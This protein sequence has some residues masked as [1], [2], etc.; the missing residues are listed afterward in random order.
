[1][2]FGI[3]LEIGPT[4]NVTKVT[5]VETFYITI[6]RSRD[7]KVCLIITKVDNEVD[8]IFDDK[9]EEV[10]KYDDEWFEFMD[11]LKEYIN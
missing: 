6:S 7:R 2:F 8:S 1:M 9:G 10:D 3:G 11:L 5:K 4:I